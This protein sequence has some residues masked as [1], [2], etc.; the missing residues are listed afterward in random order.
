MLIPLIISKID[1]NTYSS[2][3]EVSV[4]ADHASEHGRVLRDL[5]LVKLE[6]FKSE[7]N[8]NQLIL[9]LQQ[10]VSNDQPLLVLSSISWD[11]Y[12][13]LEWKRQKI[14]V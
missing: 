1:S 9:A 3:G 2:N 13:D 10:I 11:R 4:D 7:D 14:Y 12:S 5:K 8:K 6:G